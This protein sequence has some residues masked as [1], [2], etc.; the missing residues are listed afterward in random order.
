MMRKSWL[1]AA[2]GT[3]LGAIALLGLIGW[4]AAGLGLLQAGLPGCG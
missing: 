3:G 1:I 2:V 4:R